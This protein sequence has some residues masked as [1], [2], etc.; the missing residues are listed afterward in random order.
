MIKTD[1]C[2]NDAETELLL[3]LGSPADPDADVRA[4]S[5]P[6]WDNAYSVPFESIARMPQTDFEQRYFN[7]GA[8]W[9]EEVETFYEDP[10]G[11]SSNILRVDAQ[12]VRQFYEQ[13][14][15]HVR[16]NLPS[17]DG[18]DLTNNYHPSTCSTQA[19]VCFWT[20]DCQ[21]NDGNGNCDDPYDLKCGDKEPADNTDMCCVD[22]DRGNTSTGFDSFEGTL[23]SNRSNHTSMFFV[24]SRVAF[25]DFI[26]S[27]KFIMCWST[28]LPL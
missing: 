20:T 25:F 13:E 17:Y 21:A 16:V 12:G 27:H 4:L 18:S 22:L 28:Y 9:N 5:I 11:E 14:S 15:E 19:V 3:H 2:V 8:D 7:G 10:L 1:D 26:F 6:A 24:S 23:V